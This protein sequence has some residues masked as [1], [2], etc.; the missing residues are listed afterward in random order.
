MDKPIGYL[1][2]T[3]SGDMVLGCVACAV[4]RET[5]VYRINVYPYRG[6][7]DRCGACLVEPQTSAWPELFGRGT[8]D[9]RQ[10]EVTS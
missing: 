2:Y 3:A 7:C 10:R 9:S 5:P 8:F 4:R 6:T 1:E